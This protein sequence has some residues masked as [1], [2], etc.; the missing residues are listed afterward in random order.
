MELRRASF[1]GATVESG[2]ER[3]GGVVPE[4][5]TPSTGGGPETWIPLSQV[6]SE[7]WSGNTY[8]SLMHLVC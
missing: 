2:A 6:D 7:D 5:E 3:A 8:F 1:V 4:A